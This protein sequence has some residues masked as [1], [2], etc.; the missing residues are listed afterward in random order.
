VGWAV[1]GAGWRGFGWS[2]AGSQEWWGAGGLTAAARGVGACGGQGAGHSHGHSGGAG[3]FHRH[4][5]VG[6]C[7]FGDPGGLAQ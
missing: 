3:Q 2:A 5:Q 6:Q 4:G 7:P 1:S